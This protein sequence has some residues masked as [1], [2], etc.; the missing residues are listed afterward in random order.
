[1]NYFTEYVEEQKFMYHE[2]F[3]KYNLQSTIY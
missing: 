3:T 2:P 1:M